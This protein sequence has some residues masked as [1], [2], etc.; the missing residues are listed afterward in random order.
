MHLHSRQ[1]CER[2]GHLASV[3]S[4]RFHRETETDRDLAI[5]PTRSIFPGKSIAI[6]TNR[7]CIRRG[8]ERSSP[9]FLANR[10]VDVTRL[11]SASYSTREIVKDGSLT[12]RVAIPFLD[13]VCRRFVSS[14]GRFVFRPSSRS[15]ENSHVT[16]A[17]PADEKSRSRYA[18]ADFASIFV[19]SESIVEVAVF[20]GFARPIREHQ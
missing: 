17:R 20:S 13:V 18:G 3:S 8:R 9:L 14:R 4:G 11:K 19:H 1:K 7:K 15:Q 6:T 2:R 10:S 5:E 16:H 12:V